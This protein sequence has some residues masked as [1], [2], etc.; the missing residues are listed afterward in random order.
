MFSQQKN[1]NN[2]TK[3]ILTELAIE[4]LSLYRNCR[5][6]LFEVAF[7]QACSK[8]LERTQRNETIGSNS[9]SDSNSNIE[10]REANIDDKVD[11]LVQLIE[12]TKVG[13]YYYNE[14]GYASTVA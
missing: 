10:D 2:S 6:I 1:N 13:S 4:F 12:S 5:L 11:I 7:N 9:D 3:Y 14:E 8:T